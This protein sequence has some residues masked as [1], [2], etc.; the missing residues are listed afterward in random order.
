MG[1]S[2]HRFIIRLYPKITRQLPPAVYYPHLYPSF[3]KT[4]LIDSKPRIDFYRGDFVV[5][6]NTTTGKGD[7]MDME[8]N[9]IPN[10]TSETREVSKK[11]RR[12]FFLEAMNDLERYSN[13]F[14]KMKNLVEE[15]NSRINFSKTIEFCTNRLINCG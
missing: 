2:I 3:D 1:R 11:I 12:R 8:K 14:E 13:S 15:I 9:I 6:R 4:L 5:P 10:E 7:W